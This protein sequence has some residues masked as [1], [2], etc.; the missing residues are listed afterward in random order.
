MVGAGGGGLWGLAHTHATPPVCRAI[1]R[2]RIDQ[3]AAS[4]LM[5]PPSIDAPCFASDGLRELPTSRRIALLAHFSADSFV[6]FLF[7]SFVI[8]F[9]FFPCFKSFFIRRSS[10]AM[11]SPVLAA[12]GFGD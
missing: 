9:F 8:D 6:V 12:G 4:P 7:Y 10:A 11:A 3:G 2:R 1:D 5:K